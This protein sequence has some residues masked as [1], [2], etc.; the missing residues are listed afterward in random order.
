MKVAFVTNFCPHYRVAAFETLGRNYDIDYLFC[1]AGNE[2]YWQQSHG[3]RTGD[4]RYTYLPSFQLTRR[5]RAVPTLLPTLWQGNYDVFVK[6][7]NGR[8]ALPISYLVARLQRKPFVLWT[9]I[10]MSLQTPFHRLVF[11]LTRWIYRHSDAIVVPG[12]HLKRYLVGIDVKP[13]KVF[14]APNA[15]DNSAYNQTVSPEAKEALRDKLGLG[16]RKT[17]LYLGRLEE[18]KGVEY[19]IRAFALLKSDDAVLIVAGDGSLHQRLRT[20]VIEQGTQEKIRFSGY[21][22]PEETLPYY[23]I[24]DL[25]VLPSVTMPTGKEVWGVVVNEAM[26]QGLPVVVTDAVGAAAG[27]LVRSGVNGFI[28]PERDTIALAQAIERI[29]ADPALRE[30][31]SRNARRIIGEWDNEQMV[32]G[33]RQAIEYAVRQ[34]NA[35]DAKG[36][37]QRAERIGRKWQRIPKEE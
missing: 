24:A 3:I 12:E 7:I 23:A 21:V 8:F 17:V 28:V 4:F 25:F 18:I 19:L 36:Q 5:I 9:E 34:R 35:K 32:R 33:F 2:W 30:E 15:I 6:C 16:S 26:N 11:P 13:E 37:G 14:I 27:G 22:R 1:S 10:W 20:L 31:L 29:L